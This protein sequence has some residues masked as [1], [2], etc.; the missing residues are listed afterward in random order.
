MKKVLSLA[1]LMLSCSGAFAEN[2]QK[3]VLEPTPK[4]TCQNCENKIKKNVRFV[5][6]TKTIE[7][8]LKTNTVTIVYD[9]D[10]ASLTDYVAAFKK[11]GREI[12]QK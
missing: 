8:D 9:A 4:M 12:K 1:L 7:T 11:I 5:K 3:L 2:M 10:K 6:G